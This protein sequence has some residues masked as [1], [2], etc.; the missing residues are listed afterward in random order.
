M[1]YDFYL[2]YIVL[3]CKMVSGDMEM[4]TNEFEE[5][6][7]NFLDRHEYDEAESYLFSMVRLAFAAG[8]QAAGGA[9]PQAE[10]IFELIV[11][12]RKK[13]PAES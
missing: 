1:I 2:L 8:W 11:P 9:P 10:R 7:S 12:E 4:Y 3:S 5:A 13:N 6:F